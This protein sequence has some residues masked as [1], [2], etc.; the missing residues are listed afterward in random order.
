MSDHFHGYAISRDYRG[1]EIQTFDART[2]RRIST[3]FIRPVPGMPRRLRYDEL[4]LHMRQVG[5]TPPAYQEPS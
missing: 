1:V 5:L 3:L 4:S 2:H